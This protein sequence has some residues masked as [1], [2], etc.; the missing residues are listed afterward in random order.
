MDVYLGTDPNP[1]TLLFGSAAVQGTVVVQWAGPGW[2][3]GVTYRWTAVVLT[4]DGATI[5]LDGHI[6]AKATI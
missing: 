4:V 1:S 2:L 3:P 6:P 5:S